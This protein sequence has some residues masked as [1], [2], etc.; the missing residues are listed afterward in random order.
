[1]ARRLGDVTNDSAATTRSSW[2]KET[3]CGLG[4]R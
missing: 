4:G 2:V 3:T 1:L